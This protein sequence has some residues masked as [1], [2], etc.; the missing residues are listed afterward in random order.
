VLH[1]TKK[2]IQAP[3]AGFSCAPFRKLA[4]Q[5]GQ[6]DFC[7]SEMLSAKHIASG[8]IQ[9]KRYYYK[10]PAE[11]PLCI[12]LAANDPNDLA[13]ALDA[14][15]QW[16]PDMIDLNCG[17]PQP[18][19]RKKRYGSQLLADSAK[20]GQLIKT[21]KSLTPIPVLVKIRVDNRSGD[22]YNQS[23]A[24]AVQEAGADAITV[25]GRHWTEDYD[26]PVS[27]RDIAAI[28]Q[29]VSL[30]VIG[31]GDVFDTASA[32][33]MFEET[34]CDALMIGRASVGQPWI[35]DQIACELE[36]KSYA[37]PDLDEIGRIFLAH[38]QGLMGLEGEKIALL[39]SRKL[40]KYYTRDL[41]DIHSI[42]HAE[43]FGSFSMLERLVSQFFVE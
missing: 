42:N 3:L 36:N 40:L 5:W 8:S 20:L 11:G 27:Y 16:G 21:M 19:I 34:G 9:R 17:C 10:D 15:L 30:P 32:R 35:F 33:R 2:L 43:S 14:V 31:N 7:C 13:I 4:H 18:K 6:P 23:V 39:Q 25:H 37:T 22:D 26:V 41:V 28:K 1:F 24:A 29:A 38:V 12:Q